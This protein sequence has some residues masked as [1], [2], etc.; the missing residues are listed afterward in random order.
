MILKMFLICKLIPVRN[1]AQ[2]RRLKICV[3]LSMM[4][5]TF[6]NERSMCL[7]ERQLRGRIGKLL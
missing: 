5:Y 4:C 2:N 3:G 7:G 6:G 1:I